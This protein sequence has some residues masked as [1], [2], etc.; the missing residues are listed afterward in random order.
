MKLFYTSQYVFLVSILLIVSMGYGQKTS[1]ST[2]SK[3]EMSTSSN[4]VSL[5]PL[6]QYRKLLIEK[7]YED[8]LSIVD[9]AISE[10]AKILVKEHPEISLEHIHLLCMSSAYFDIYL[11]LDRNEE[12]LKKY[13]ETIS[14]LPEEQ[15][16]N[17]RHTIFWSRLILF[18][19]LNRVDD[20]I[21]E[22]NNLIN[23]P[24]PDMA[25]YLLGYLYGTAG[26]TMKNDYEKAEHYLSSAKYY[27][28]T[29]SSKY[30]D[31]N[32]ILAKFKKHLEFCE[33]FLIYLRDEYELKPTKVQ[34]TTTETSDGSI[35][36]VY[37]LSI[38]A[39]S[40]KT[41]Q[42]LPEDE[43]DTIMK[44]WQKEKEQEQKDKLQE[45]PFLK[46][47]RSNFTTNKSA[48]SIPSDT[49]TLTPLQ[50][51]RKLLKEKK[52][53]EALP[54]VEAAMSEKAKR[55]AEKYPNVSLEEIRFECTSTAYLTINLLLGRDEEALKK[56]EETLSLLSDKQ[57][58]NTRYV[59][60]I[61][62]LLRSYH[63]NNDVITECNFLVYKFVPDAKDYLFGYL[64]GALGYAMKNDYAKAEQY[65]SSAKLYFTEGSQDYNNIIRK[66]LKTHLD[67]CDIFLTCLQDEYDLT[68]KMDPIITETSD[69]TIDGRVDFTFLAVSKKTGQPIT[70]NEFVEKMRKKYGGKEQ[71]QKN[72]LQDD[73][74]L[75]E[76]RTNS[77]ETNSQNT[78]EK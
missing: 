39:V 57:S 8:A 64:Y 69:G 16:N 71:K 72:K 60:F 6:Q 76:L 53:K 32:V 52:Y 4:T 35:E 46:E 77:Q 70:E 48:I 59:S 33:I 54:L 25:D 27:F 3:L 43:F 55:E 58:N 49:E 44:K 22:C 74:F 67:Q 66:M 62:K 2:K 17:G 34:P 38:E 1:D 56:F 18:S 23:R 45:Y 63:Q 42:P 11:L 75:R 21:N 7:K 51:Y 30:Q 15:F 78:L 68:L 26:Y 9:A 19:R 28:I 50:Q 10:K 14:Q 61:L 73:P 24:S 29:V 12:A 36:F 31:N 47:L 20:F 13:E 37:E 40:K 41:G 5:T 65:L